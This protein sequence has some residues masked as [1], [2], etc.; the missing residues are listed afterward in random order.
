[1]RIL[2]IG[3]QGTIG[4]AVAAELKQRH[5][6]VSA[7][8]S[9]GDFKVDITDSA[10]V[11][12]L[13]D[14][15]GAI[16]AVVIAAG[17]VHFG[18]LGE[19][20]PEQW[21]IGLRDK[22]MGQVNVALEAAKRLKPGGSVTLVAGTLSHDPIRYGASASLVNAALEGFVRAAAVEFP[23]GV[24]INAISPTVVRESLSAYGPYFRGYEG[25]PA[26]RVA[27][28][29]SRSVE[30]AQTGQIYSVE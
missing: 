14:D 19:I 12:K 6:I 26:N 1:M 25:V 21:D 22:L 10:S 2:I 7:G 3:A 28:A 23:A 9:G 13:F 18:P 29:F 30:G 5:E 8:R 4:S 16:D 11:R 15:A 27:L 17:N 24:R 20:T